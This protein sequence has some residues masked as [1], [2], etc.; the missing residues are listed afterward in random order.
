MKKHQKHPLFVRISHWLN[1]PVLAL[2]VWSGI[3]IYWSND[4]YWPFFPQGFY[5]FFGIEQRLA[6]GM[7]LH[8]TFGWIFTL[9]GLIY[10]GWALYSRHHRELVPDRKAVRDLAPTVLHDLGLSDQA[11]AHGLYNAAQKFAYSGVIALAAIEVLTGLA[12]YKP[13]Q[14][15]LLASLFGGYEAA[16]LIHFVIMLLLCA[17]FVMHLTQV[18]RAGWKNFRAMVA[19]SES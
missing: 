7:S 12:I 1:F 4:V 13:V 2:M 18:I 16:R 9:N 8:F 5:Q 19:G 3:L 11:P 6:E 15:G 10:L 14:L 17:F